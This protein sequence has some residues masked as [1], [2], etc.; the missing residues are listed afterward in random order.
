M[1][2]WIVWDPQRFLPAF[3]RSFIDGLVEY[4]RRTYPGRGFERCAPPV[5]RPKE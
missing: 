3:A 1:W 2:G 5:P 4:T